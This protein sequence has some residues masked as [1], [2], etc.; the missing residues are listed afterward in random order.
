MKSKDLDAKGALAE[1]D[2]LQLHG[3]LK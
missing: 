1:N 3:M 2:V